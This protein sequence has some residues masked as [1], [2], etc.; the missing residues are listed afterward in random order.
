MFLILKP[1]GNNEL[2]QIKKQVDIDTRHC[3][4]RFGFVY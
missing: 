3:L 4:Q 2:G 1:Q